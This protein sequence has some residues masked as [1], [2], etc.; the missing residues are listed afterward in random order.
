MR[1]MGRE[2]LAPSFSAAK[3]KYTVTVVTDHGVTFKNCLT[4]RSF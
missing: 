2:N 3:A 4:K 1:K